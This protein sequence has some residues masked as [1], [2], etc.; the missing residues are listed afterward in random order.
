MDRNAAEMRASLVREPQALVRWLICGSIAGVL[1]GGSYAYLWVTIF[2]LRVDSAMIFVASML[3]AGVT[4]A[5]FA[6]WQRGRSSNQ[7]SLCTW[8]GFLTGLIVAIVVGIGG[9]GLLQMMRPVTLTGIAFIP[10]MAGFLVGGLLDR[11]FEP[12]LF[13]AAT[14]S[15]DQP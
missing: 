10:A 11:L 14:E 12:W 3:L 1:F 2:E 13:L 5:A 9:V 7:C 15:R 8:L 4:G 6:A